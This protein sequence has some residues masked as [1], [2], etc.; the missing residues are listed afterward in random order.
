ME[1][2]TQGPLNLLRRLSS[3]LDRDGIHS[4][5]LTTPGSTRK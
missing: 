5:I 2:I 1:I 4:E 3:E